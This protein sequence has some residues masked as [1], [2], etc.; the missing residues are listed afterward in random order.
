MTKFFGYKNNGM[1]DAMKNRNQDETLVYQ[2][3]KLFA[4]KIYT[5]TYICI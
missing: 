4:F 5:Y 2:A 1:E 3:I